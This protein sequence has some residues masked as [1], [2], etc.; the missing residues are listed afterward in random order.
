M[1]NAAF[2]SWLPPGGLILDI[3]CANGRSTQA[4]RHSGFRA[5]G[6]EIDPDLVDQL[7]R[8]PATRHLPAGRADARR[9]PLKGGVA[10]GAILIEVLEHISDPD[11]VLREIRRVVRPGGRLCVAVPTAYTE[12]VYDRLHPQ[13]LQNAGHLNRFKRQDLQQRLERAGFDVQRITPQNLAPAVSWLA[14]AIVRSEAD[15]TG[16]LLEHRWIDY[17]VAGG[18]RL[19]DAIPGV[20]RIVAA[21]RAR[22]GKSRYFYC[23]AT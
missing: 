6:L 14:H 20:R 19:G 15:H 5:V 18:F 4:L 21:L 11:A 12:A 1:T 22:F 3:G 2:D 23:V 7:R 13:Y 8:D 10:D 17:A 9:L 16:A